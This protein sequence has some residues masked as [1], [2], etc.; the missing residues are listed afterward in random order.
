M[1]AVW[2]MLAVALLSGCATD[3]PETIRTP[4]PTDI[5]LDKA[6]DNPNAV[7]GQ[8]V[9]WGGTIAA[10][11]NRTADTWLDVVVRELDSHGRPREVDQSQGRFLARANGFLDPAVYTKGREVTVAGTIEGVTTRPIGEHPY[12]YVLIKADTVH[13]WEPRV[14]R[15]DS[16]RSPYYDPFWH[17]PFW[18]WRPYPGYAPYW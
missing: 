9:R 10:V 18:P 16:Y 5:S 13:L 7:I 11:E 1:R 15:R 2:V 3:L 12:R 17:D 14:E 8:R 4:P 6:R